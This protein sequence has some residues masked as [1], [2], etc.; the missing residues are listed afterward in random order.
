MREHD[1]GVR[2]HVRHIELRRGRRVHR[3][4]HDA[5]SGTDEDIGLALRQHVDGLGVGVSTVIQHAKTMPHAHFHRF[6]GMS[7]TCQPHVGLTCLLGG[8]TNLVVGIQDSQ[9]DGRPGLS[10]LSPESKNL[11]IFAPLSAQLLTKARMASGPLPCSA[12][13]P[14]AR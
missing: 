3:R 7:V 5:E 13:L 8:S 2:L 4:L 9:S 1:G 11:T 14:P 6:R 12:T 10:A